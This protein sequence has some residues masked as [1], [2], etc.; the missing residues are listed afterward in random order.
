MTLLEREPYLQQLAQLWYTATA[1]LG[2]AVLVSGEARLTSRE[3]EVLLLLADGLSNA[4]IAC[5]LSTSLKTVDHQVSAILA[6]LDV[7]SRAQAVTEASALGLLS[8]QH[9]EAPRP[10]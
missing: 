7:H 9:G 2:R 10:P 8:S 4:E 3:A 6:K 1:G 5:R